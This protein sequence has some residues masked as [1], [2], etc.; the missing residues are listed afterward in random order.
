MGYRLMAWD[1]DFRTKDMFRAS[2]RE[3]ANFTQKK[4]A[5][6]AAERFMRTYPPRSEDARV[7][8]EKTSSRWGSTT[9][10]K[11]G[12]GPDGWTKTSGDPRRRRSR[13][14]PHGRDEILT[15]DRGRPI[16]KPRPEDYSTHV[17]YVRAYHAYKDRVAAAAS[18]GFEEGWRRSHKKRRDCIGVH[19]HENMGRR[20]RDQKRTR[21]TR[22]QQAYVHRKIRILRRE[23]PEW[24]QKQVVAVAISYARRR[25]G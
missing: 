13:R 17:E 22:S 6:E 16:E 11:W 10:A 21:L 1:G 2:G 7:I 12:K 3:H 4:A 23:H 5:H 25:E 14:D 9:E 18:R 15:D 8:L 24:K 19:T 20:M